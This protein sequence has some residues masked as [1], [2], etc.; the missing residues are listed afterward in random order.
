[1]SDGHV[2]TGIRVLDLTRVLAGPWCTQMLSDFGADVVKVERPDVGDESRSLGPP[3]YKGD[4]GQQVS[5]YFC[6]TNRGKRSVTLDLTSERDV[7]T[8][9]VLASQCD[10]L[11][12]NFKVGTLA[13]HGLDYA[14]VSRTNPKVVYCSITG[15]GQ[16]GP[17]AARPAY[18]TTVQGMG[19]LMSVTGPP[20]GAPGAGPTKAGVPV[21]DVLTGVY[22]LS[23]ILMALLE[24]HRSGLGQHIDL[25]LLDVSVNMLS[26]NATNFLA[27]GEV[28]TRYGNELQGAVPSDA[29]QCK[30][31]HLMIR[32]GTNPQ[33]RKLCIC[34]DLPLL[35]DDPRFLTNELRMQ[36]RHDL[37]ATLR[38]AFEAR[39]RDEWLAILSAGD[40][41]CGPIND[42]ADVFKDPQVRARENVVLLEKAGFEGFRVLANPF[43]LSRTPAIYASPPTTL[44]ECA[45]DSFNPGGV[46]LAR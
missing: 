25:S 34:L 6:A 24:R 31:G 16:T 39:T 35:A 46:W 1:M 18:D 13:R 11:V 3:Y 30:D 36:H 28:P 27:S 33:F 5:A 44:G 40:V 15:F 9:R 43:R 21:A 22:A 19:G 4:D 20:D 45:I 17:Y 10:V 37:M 38:P 23:G 2:L 26:V 14:V 41:P 42:F 12:E 32:V 29:M 7:A 8:L